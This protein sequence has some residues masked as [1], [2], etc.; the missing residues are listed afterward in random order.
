MST[1]ETPTWQHGPITTVNLPLPGEHAA[2]GVTVHIVRG[3]S[4]VALI[5]SGIVWAYETLEKSIADADF[6]K[7]EIKL[8]LNTH[9]H[10]DHVGNNGPIVEETGCLV[11]AHPLRAG[12]I[13][14]N[15]ANADFFVRMYPDVEPEFD[16]KEEYL[17]WMSRKSA[18]VNLHLTEGAVV[19]LGSARLEV[20]E[21]PGHSLC[22]IGFFEENTHAL[23]FGDSLMPEASPNLYLYE[24][25]NVLRDTC[26]KIQRLISERDV[27][28]VLSGHEDPLSADQATEWADECFDRSVKIEEAILEAIREQPGITLGPL[29][30]QV[31]ENFDKLREWR[32]LITI[33][34]HLKD[35]AQRGTLEQRGDGWVVASG[36]EER[37]GR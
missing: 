18:P 10:M 20:V 25:P 1:Q 37:V 13:A 34:G 3:D 5:D 33:G 32:A 7:S 9:E 21:L 28:V 6:D 16:P 15:E 19:D 12:L 4:G 22:E 35:L 31:V 24:D 26:R 36:A 27:Q 2:V 8:L 11:G 17:D 29:R 23:I 14:D 30:D